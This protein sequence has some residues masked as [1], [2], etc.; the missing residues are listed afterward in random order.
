MVADCVLA[1][2]ADSVS[3]LQHFIQSSRELLIIAALIVANV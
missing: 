2:I 1:I 3:G